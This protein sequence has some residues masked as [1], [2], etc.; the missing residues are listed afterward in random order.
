MKKPLQL[1]IE[2]LQDPF[3]LLKVCQLLRESSAGQSLKLLVRGK[4]IPEELRKI[5]TAEY[6]EITIIQ[7]AV[8]ADHIAILIKI[9]NKPIPEIF[10]PTGNGGGGL[11]L[12]GSGVK[13]YFETSRKRQT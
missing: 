5:L 13:F 2:T 11:Q 7:A 3:T 4:T 8:P 6:Y 10:P 1:Y 12:K 9:K